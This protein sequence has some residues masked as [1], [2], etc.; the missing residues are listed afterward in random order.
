MDIAEQIAATN[1]DRVYLGVGFHSGHGSARRTACA[2][3]R[4]KG[5]VLF[6]GLP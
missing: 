4:N 3:N 5:S 6:V 1:A 2:Q